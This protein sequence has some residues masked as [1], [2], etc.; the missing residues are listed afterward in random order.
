ML[1]PSA[2]FLSRR[3]LLKSVG[4]GA[5][6]APFLP[7]Q[8]AQAAAPKRLVVWWTPNGIFDPEFTPQGNATQYTF[9]KILAPLEKYKSR[10]LIL[11]E[12]DLKCFFEFP[13]PNNHGE[14]L[15]QTLCAR[16]VIEEGSTWLGGG[17]S[18]D[19][20]IAQRMNRAGSFDGLN[21]CAG[22]YAPHSRISYRA[23]RDGVTAQDNPHRVFDSLFKGLMDAS[24]ESM[25]RLR[26][27]RKSSIDL[28]RAEITSLRG[29]LGAEDRRKLES[30][31]EHLRSQEL[32][33]QKSAIGPGCEAPDLKMHE[34]QPS[35]YI[36]GGRQMAANIFTAMR[37]DLAR[38]STFA[39]G[40]PSS[41]EVFSWVGSTSR[42]HDLSH[43]P[44]PAVG[45]TE[46]EQLTNIGKWQAE[47]FKKFLDMLDSVP[48]D[49]GTMLDNSVVM[50]T[51]EH[52][53]QF[54]SHERRD[55]PF[56]LAGSAGKSLK[57]GQFMRFGGRAHADLYV[58]LCHAMG[59]ADV[60][61]FGEEALCKGPLPGLAT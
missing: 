11:K 4:A 8:V 39:W 34:G 55:I 1:I 44:T 33:L 18:I 24:G 52:K 45:S 19:Q 37:C 36:T 31:L 61:T 26:A 2:K 23:A 32:R 13:V 9:G 30:H 43:A 5:A 17:P 27:R 3:A 14:P 51:S 41:N 42:H 22:A 25:G 54:G 60:K 56:L 49:G 58:S 50:W 21:V 29:T 57:T 10:L 46:W 20:Y 38:V 48:E 12:L 16:R 6:L 59:F 15:S 28:V 35:G 7:A 47:E 53:C 40:G